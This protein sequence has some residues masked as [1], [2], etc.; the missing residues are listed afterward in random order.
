MQNCNLLRDPDKDKELNSFQL[1]TRKSTL[2][3]SKPPFYA[4][5]II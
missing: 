1:Q 3:I 4:T 2:L 5:F